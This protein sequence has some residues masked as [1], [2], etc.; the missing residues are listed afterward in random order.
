MDQNSSKETARALAEKLAHEA[1][2]SKAEEIR[3]L[4]VA[5]FL[6]I[7]DYFLIVTTQS[8]RQTKALAESLKTIAKEVS[9]S[10]G[11][12]EGTAS[13]SWMLCD[14]DTVVVH[15]LTEEAREFYDLDG[16]WADAE[17]VEFDPAA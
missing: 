10:R 3:I 6:F 4:D 9:G 12:D 5:E 7:T 11:H 13:S 8:V 16:L 2:L 17:E 1:F 15:I 14:F